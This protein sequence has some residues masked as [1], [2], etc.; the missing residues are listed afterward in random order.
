MYLK[1]AKKTIS[2]KHKVGSHSASYANLL[3]VRDD[4]LL[5]EVGESKRVL[6]G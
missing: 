3:R 5:F 2:M 6:K 1:Y 4:E